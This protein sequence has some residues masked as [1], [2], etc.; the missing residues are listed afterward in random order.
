MKVGL[1]VLLALLL[2]ARLPLPASCSEIN[3][4]F[5]VQDARLQK[6]VTVPAGFILV[7][8]LLQ[9]LR[10]QTGITIECDPLTDSTMMPLVHTQATQ[11]P[12]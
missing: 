10:K 7:G 12:Q 2:L 11:F 1:R 5:R 6:H 9:D 3:E 8:D 4:R